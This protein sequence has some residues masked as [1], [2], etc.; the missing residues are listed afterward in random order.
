MYKLYLTKLFLLSCMFS[1]SCM[2]ADVFEWTD[3]KGRKHYSDTD[4]NE[5][6][7]VL[8]NEI[9][10]KTIHPEPINEFKVDEVLLSD[11]QI[12]SIKADNDQRD[13]ERDALRKKSNQQQMHERDNNEETEAGLGDAS[14]VWA[15]KNGVVKNIYFNSSLIKTSKGEFVLRTEKKACSVRTFKEQ[16]KHII[17][18][19]SDKVGFITVCWQGLVSQIPEHGRGNRTLDRHFSQSSGS[20]DIGGVRYGVKNYKK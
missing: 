7:A 10:V 16:R 17:N 14:D 3:E 15:W 8:S 1:A 6:A 19:N 9:D 12:E 2:M 20:V 4:P 18:V 13:L 5:T 11:Q